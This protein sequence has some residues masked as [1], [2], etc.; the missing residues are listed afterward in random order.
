MT[1]FFKG[2]RSVQVAV[3]GQFKPGLCWPCERGWEISTGWKLV[4]H[5]PWALGPFGDDAKQAPVGLPGPAQ[6]Q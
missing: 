6:H 4:A 3:G 5:G 1:S 2:R